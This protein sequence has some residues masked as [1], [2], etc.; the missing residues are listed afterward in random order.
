MIMID[1][2]LSGEKRK[3]FRLIL[4]AGSGVSEVSARLSRKDVRGGLKENG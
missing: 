1:F 2:F 4:T 3:A